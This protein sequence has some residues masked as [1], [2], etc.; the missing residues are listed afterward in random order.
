LLVYFGLKYSPEFDELL[1]SE[2]PKSCDEEAKSYHLNDLCRSLQAQVLPRYV[3]LL[4][5][6]RNNNV[7]YPTP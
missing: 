2:F 5:N 4:S 3:V 1:L 7:P 6:M